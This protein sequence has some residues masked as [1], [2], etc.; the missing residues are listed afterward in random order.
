[1]SRPFLLVFA[2]ACVALSGCGTLADAMA[3][4]LGD[5][6][7]FYR[8]VRMDVWAIE[9]GTAKLLGRESNAAD[10]NGRP[11]QAEPDWEARSWIA[12]A[13]YTLDV[14]VSFA[15]DTAMIPFLGVSF[16]IHPNAYRL[17]ITDGADD[18]I[19]PVESRQ[20]PKKEASTAG[21]VFEK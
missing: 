10:E 1:M 17:P 11:S 19:D 18:Y 8:G 4:P 12:F 3:G 13:I 2:L 21:V 5:G 9:A 16:L 6:V 20:S 14:P 15:V 7:V